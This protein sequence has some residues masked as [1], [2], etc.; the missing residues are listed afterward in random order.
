MVRMQIN[1]WRP[2]LSKGIEEKFRKVYVVLK[3]LRNKN[4]YLKYK[5]QALWL[6]RQFVVYNK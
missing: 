3:L 6:K 5:E 2:Y 4:R 1:N